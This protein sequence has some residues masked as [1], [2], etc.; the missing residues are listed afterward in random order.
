VRVVLD[1][2]ILISALISE[3]GAPYLLVEAWLDGRFSLVSSEDQIDELLRV[4]RYPQVRRYIEAA[5]A[6]WLI[7]RIRAAGEFVRRLP[8]VDASADP[9]DNFLLAMA[10]AG[11]ADFLATGDKRHVLALGTWKSTRILTSRQ[12]AEALKL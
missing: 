12:L 11:N 2:N 10:Q 4:S 7:N 8:Q 3:S 5:E 9:E 1:T 6:G